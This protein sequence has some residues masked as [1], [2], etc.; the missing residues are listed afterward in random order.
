MGWDEANSNLI[1]TETLEKVLRQNQDI[2]TINNPEIFTQFI[3]DNWVKAPEIY[4]KIR[5]INSGLIDV[6]IKQADT[7]DLGKNQCAVLNLGNC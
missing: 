4:E 7:L 5:K 3:K 1:F 6:D 2:Y